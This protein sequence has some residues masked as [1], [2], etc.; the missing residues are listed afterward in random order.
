MET[1]FDGFRSDLTQDLRAFVWVAEDWYRVGI[2]SRGRGSW[3]LEQRVDS[4]NSGKQLVEGL[5]NHE[6]GI[7]SVSWDVIRSGSSSSPLR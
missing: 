1:I 7:D 6:L 5:A 2:Y 4:L 3:I